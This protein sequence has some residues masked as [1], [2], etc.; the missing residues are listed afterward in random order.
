MS[1]KMQITF[2]EDTTQK[3]REWVSELMQAHAD[4]DCEWCGC[5]IMIQIGPSYLRSSVFAG[6]NELGEADAVLVDE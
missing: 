4:E 2:D 1:K 3:Y 5:T 6:Q